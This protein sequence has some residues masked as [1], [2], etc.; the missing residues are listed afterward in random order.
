MV[1]RKDDNALFENTTKNKGL[2]FNM[3]EITVFS[4][5]DSRSLSTWSN[6]PY[7]FTKTLEEK[8]IHVNRI[9]ISPNKILNRIFN[10]LSYKIFKRCLHLRACP[11]FHRTRMHRYII[12]RR[13]K[14]ASEQYPHSELNLFLSFAFF[15]PYSDE[16]NVLWCDWTDAIVIERLGRAPMWYE[17]LSLKHERRVMQRADFVFSLFPK[18][19]QQMQ[20]MYGRE[21]LYLKQ[22]VV[23][24]VWNQSFDL[25]RIIQNRQATRQ[26]LFIGSHFYKS[27]ALKLIHVFQRLKSSEPYLSLH[28]IGMIQDELPVTADLHCYGYLHKDI[29]KERDQYYELLTHC[30]CFVNPTKRWSGYSSSVE[31]MYYGSPVVVSPYDDF[32][33]EFGRNIDFGFYCHKD[34][35]AQQILRVLHAE[36][37]A[38]LCRSAHEHVKTYTWS[39]YINIFLSE[40]DS[41]G[42]Q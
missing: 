3:K 7:L 11:E 18:C 4:C 26:I 1:G 32:V 15:N 33:T 12:Y 34:D 31:A 30:T 5:G 8:G 2:I 19:A 24:T 29:P 14:K 21:V 37:Y 28:I 41:R 6:V 42:I 20:K 38:D 22:N 25:E 17:R 16:P 23:N 27:G 39:N 40:L 10:T 13:I 36:N 35:L 9:D